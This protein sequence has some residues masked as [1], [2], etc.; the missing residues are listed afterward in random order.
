[1]RFEEKYP[2]MD[3]YSPVTSDGVILGLVPGP[4][5]S[6]KATTCFVEISFEDYICSEECCASAWAMYWQ[7]ECA[8]Q[9]DP[10]DDPFDKTTDLDALRRRL[11]APDQPVWR[12]DP[13][14][15]FPRRP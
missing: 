2:E 15:L 6:C 13:S 11:A 7:A 14:K 12:R 8:G 1:M 5:F 4:C 9:P 3:I 10:C